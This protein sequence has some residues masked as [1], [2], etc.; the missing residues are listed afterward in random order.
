MNVLIRIP[1]FLILGSILLAEPS[2][3]S[4][5]TQRYESRVQDTMRKA[6]FSRWKPLEVKKRY[7]VDALKAQ[8][9]TLDY[10]DIT[11]FPYD[12]SWNKRIAIVL[13]YFPE[14][15]TDFINLIIPAALNLQDDL[16]IPASAT[17]A[18]A[19]YESAY[20]ESEL[21][22]AHY[23]FF[24]LKAFQTWKGERI[25][26]KTKD[27]GIWTEAYFRSYPTFHEGVL[28]FGRLLSS[29]DRYRPAFDSKTGHEFVR[30]VLESGYCPD[31]D[32]Y[33]NILKII[34]QYR[35]HALDRI[36]A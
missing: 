4:V 21:A 1:V 17:V 18:M 25:L 22:R 35:L 27:E 20:G 12:T 36:R 10:G 7:I 31:R 13:S 14:S 16:Q 23:N 11:P 3:G 34:K 6:G 9:S 33:S 8:K 2:P 28:N 5:S 19:I 15:K 29:S 32:Y 26:M 24:G 30:L